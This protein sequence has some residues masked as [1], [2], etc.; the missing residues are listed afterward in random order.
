MA[1]AQSVTIVNKVSIN[2]VEHMSFGMVEPFGYMPRN[3]IAGS[4]GS[5]ISN[6]VRNYQIDFHFQC[7]C[8]SL[9]YHQLRSVSLSPHPCQHVLSLEF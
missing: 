6:F 1:F 7:G 4:S 3:G 5:T 8:T 9:Q 2:T